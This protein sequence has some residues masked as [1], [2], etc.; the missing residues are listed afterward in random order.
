MKK[1]LTVLTRPLLAAGLTVPIWLSPIRTAPVGTHM[2]AWGCFV[3]LLVTALTLHEARTFRMPD[4]VRDLCMQ[5]IGVCGMTVLFGMMFWPTTW[6]N[7]EGK[8]V[9]LYGMA[10]A[11]MWLCLTTKRKGSASPQPG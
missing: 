1:I 5:I 11:A 4:Q 10:G 3:G 9:V 2:V 7:T 6:L 8:M